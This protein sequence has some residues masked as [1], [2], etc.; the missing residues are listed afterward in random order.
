M[1]RKAKNL[2]NS[3]VAIEIRHS[4][5]VMVLLEP[6]QKES[7]RRV[8]T[9]SIRWRYEAHSLRSEEGKEEL[10]KALKTLVDE[11]QL[12]GTT[13]NFTLSGEYCITRVVTGNSD[14][15][16]RELASLEERKDLYLLLGTE[17]KLSA[18]SIHELDAR[19]QHALLAVAN[20]K[21]L[22]VV[23]Q[24]AAAVGLSVSLVEP[25]LVALCRLLG[26]AGEDTDGPT[27]IIDSSESGLKLGISYRGQLLLGYRPAGRSTVDDVDDIFLHS[28]VRLYRYCDR[29]YGYSQGPLTRVFVCGFGEP[30]AS[31]IS[32]MQQQKQLTVHV[33]DPTT[34]DSQWEFVET[35]PGSQCCAALGTCLRSATPN[36]LTA[37]PNLIERLRAERSRPLFTESCRTFWPVAVAAMI[38]LGLFVAARQE[39]SQCHRLGQNLQVI[40]A[41]SEE[42]WKLRREIT[43]A[44]TKTT[45][46]RTIAKEATVPP[47][48]E[49]LAFVARCMPNDLWLD[50]IVADC[51]GKVALTGNSYREATIYEFGSYLESSPGW[52]Y[53]TVEGTWPAST[54]LGRTTKF[55]IQCKFDDPANGSEELNRND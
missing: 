18:R 7:S 48:G 40:E 27:L 45:H 28:L 41:S 34:V 37:G 3:V 9:R 50:K 29:Y 33:L 22:D 42:L 55:D 23:L 32:L 46:L 39:R 54:Q 38:A 26:A 4:S 1:V 47:W 31:A 6:A 51:D 25:A 8:R 17:Q 52:S 20:S 21:T 49:V 5:L 16:Q 2:A 24:V 14:R 15:V 10:L 11:E 13:V 12:A 43:E 19:H 35:D 36:E 53:V 44:E 30:V